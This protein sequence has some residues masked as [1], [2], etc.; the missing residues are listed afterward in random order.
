MQRLLVDSDVIIELTRNNQ[1]AIDV[2]SQY[3]KQFRLCVSSITRY[4][5]LIGARNKQELKDLL[6][7]LN[8][9]ETLPLN[10]RIANYA[11]QLLI[12]YNLSH[13][14]QLADGLIAATALFYHIELLSRNKK[15]FSYI[16]TL[17]LR[18][19]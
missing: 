8:T 5:L 9:F 6:Q 15:D 17:Q 1:K 11:E 10:E 4:E 7:L 19:Y 14:L 18:T 16:D 3:Q 13:N 2:L 12:A